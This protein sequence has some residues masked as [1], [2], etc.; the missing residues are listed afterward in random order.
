MFCKKPPNCLPDGRTILH[1]HQQWRRVPIAPHPASR[2]SGFW[3]LV[4]P[5]NRC[6]VVADLICISLRTWWASFHCLFVFCK[7][8]LV[9]FSLRSL[10]HF[11]IFKFNLNLFSY[12]WVLS[13]P[14]ISWM[15]VL[16]QMYLLQIFSPNL[17]LSFAND[18]PEVYHFNEVQ[19]INSFFHGAVSLVL[20]LKSHRHTQGSCWSFKLLLVFPFF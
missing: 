6:A 10:A 17:A 19:L 11:L 5:S 7:S 12:C 8:R 18:K 14:C 4:I 9:R 16:Y 2:C 3:P 20:Y 1:S 15:T 13:G